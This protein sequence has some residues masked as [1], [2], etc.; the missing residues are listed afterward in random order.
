MRM[1]RRI[2]LL[3]ASG[4]S[5]LSLLIGSFALRVGSAGAASPQYSISGNTP[6]FIKYATDQGALDPSTV[7]TVTA[8]LKL[9]NMQQLDQL[10]ASQHQK[11]KATYQ[12]WLTQ[13]QFNATYAVT[14]Q[15]LKSVTNFLTAHKLTVVTSAE[16]NSS[17]DVQG[18]AADIEKAFHVQIDNFLLDGATY[19]ANT[20]DPTIDDASGAHIDTITG[21]DD[22]DV[23]PDIAYPTSPDGQPV[24]PVAVG[25]RPNGL[26]FESQCFTGT[27]THTFTATGV[28]ATYT[29]N[30]YGADIN[31]QTPGHLPSCAYQP[32]ELQTAYNMTPLY[33]Q[34]LDGTGQTVV[35]IDAFGSPTI[36]NDA[37]VFSQLYGLPD[38]NSSNFHIYQAPGIVAN[39]PCTKRICPGT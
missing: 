15:E 39:K 4:L 19:Y 21:L 31:N 14:P 27:E 11:G 8:W 12:K 38:L 22:Y 3:T 5:I 37:E 26:F 16:D 36:K 32:S 17:V 23:T 18:T 1:S 30:R 24:K 9:H 13:S 28:S 20:S 33:K 35:I 25:S 2:I 29:G 7:L 10:V 34:G 6:G